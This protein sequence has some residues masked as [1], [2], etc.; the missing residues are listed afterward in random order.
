MR[1]RMRIL[2]V[3]MANSIHTARWVDQ[4]AGQGW[5]LH[6]FPS[7][8]SWIEAHPELGNVTLHHTG[9]RNPAWTLSTFISMVSAWR[10]GCGGAG[11]E[12]GED[13][14]PRGRLAGLIARL[15]DIVHS[16][17]SSMRLH[18]LRGEPAS[19]QVVPRGS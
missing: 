16:S 15:T 19:G 10:T 14:A 11:S 17:R 18:D 7:T 12:G 13:R 2:L 3:A 4:L 6:L 8:D 1:G 5:D 9:F